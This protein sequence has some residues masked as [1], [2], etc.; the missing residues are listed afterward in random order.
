MSTVRKDKC[1]GYCDGSKCRDG[2]TIDAVRSF[3]QMINS[4]NTQKERY[5]HEK[6][7]FKK[8]FKQ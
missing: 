5:I 2:C 7:K 3:S 4:C 8:P 1:D 6:S